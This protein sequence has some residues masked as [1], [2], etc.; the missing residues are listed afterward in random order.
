[1][2]KQKPRM[3]MRQIKFRNELDRDFHRAVRARVAH[4]FDANGCDID[5]D[6][7]SFI[8]LSPN[9]PLRRYHRYQHLYAPLMFWMVDIHT[10]FFHDFAYLF[11]RHLANMEDIR[12]PLR[13]Y[14]LFFVCK[15]TYLALMLFIPMA[16]IDLPWW[17]IGLGWLIMSFV[18]ST[19]FISLLIGTHFAEETKFP[20]VDSEGYLATG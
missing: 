4:Y 17:Q 11:K 9:Q 16:L 3:R 2:T 10:V 15:F 18:M 1:M 7:T 20:E 19:I 12:H 8:R 5:I 6:D 14:I 13:E